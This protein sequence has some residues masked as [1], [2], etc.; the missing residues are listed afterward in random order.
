STLSYSSNLNT[1][2]DK[3]IYLSSTTSFPN[4]TNTDKT[5]TP[6]LHKTPLTTLTK[7]SRAYISVV[8]ES[9]SDDNTVGDTYLTPQHTIKDSPYFFPPSKMLRALPVSQ[10]DNDYTMPTDDDYERNNYD[11][12]NSNTKPRKYQLLTP[13]RNS[14]ISLTPKV[15]VPATSLPDHTVPQRETITPT[16]YK[17]RQARVQLLK[18]K[19]PSTELNET[20]EQTGTPSKHAQPSQ[21]END[22]R[23]SY[24][25]GISLQQKPSDYDR[26]NLQA[27][28]SDPREDKTYQRLSYDKSQDELYNR[29]SY[30]PSTPVQQKVSDYYQRTDESEKSS[31]DSYP[32]NN[33]PKLLSP[34][35]L[36]AIETQNRRPQEKKYQPLVPS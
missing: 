16:K 4:N 17:L 35:R 23:D 10:F 21:N 1:S 34:E 26:R 9:D 36:D 14:A 13:T 7:N 6:P 33:P 27:Q 15:Y 20:N 24:I 3:H 28:P 30:F 31:V 5:S 22:N 11:N 19:P 25:S 29:N 18:D 32:Y 2:A 8:Y 12:D